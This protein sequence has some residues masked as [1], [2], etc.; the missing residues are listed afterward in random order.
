[1]KNNCDN[2]SIINTIFKKINEI[3]SQ[4]VNI[5]PGTT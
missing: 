1:M 5:Q 2:L 3:E 4:I